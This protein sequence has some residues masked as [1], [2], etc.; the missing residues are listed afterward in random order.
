MVTLSEQRWVIDLSQNKSFRGTVVIHHKP[1]EWGDFS[2][3]LPNQG[4]IPCSCF[5]FCTREVWPSALFSPILFDLLVRQQ[6]K[7]FKHNRGIPEY[8]GGKVWQ[9]SA[10]QENRLKKCIKCNKQCTIIKHIKEKSF[11]LCTLTSPYSQENWIGSSKFILV[12]NGCLCL[13]F[14]PVMSWRILQGALCLSHKGS[15]DR[16]QPPPQNLVRG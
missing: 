9:N 16:H 10:G 12:V 11:F 5:N 14:G 2:Q 6:D 15:W 3:V 8:V 1:H 7:I 4:C 13:C